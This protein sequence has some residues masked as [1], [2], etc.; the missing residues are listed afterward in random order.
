MYVSSFNDIMMTNRNTVQ[1]RKDKRYNC[2]LVG[3]I[4][5][6]LWMLAVAHAQWSKKRE[7]TGVCWTLSMAD[8]FLWTI[9]VAD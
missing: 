6:W 3:W 9:R 8:V 5:I 4:W 2:W 7:W 1:Y